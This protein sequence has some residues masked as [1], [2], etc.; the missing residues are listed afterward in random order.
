MSDELVMRYGQKIQATYA[1][2]LAFLKDKLPAVLKAVQEE[3]GG[4]RID[5]SVDSDGVISLALDGH[6]LPLQTLLGQARE[7]MAQFDMPERPA[8]E[9]RNKASLPD[10]ETTLNQDLTDYLRDY[11]LDHRDFST[12]NRIDALFVNLGGR[13]A[14]GEHA[15]F[16]GNHI[17]IVIVFGSGYGSHLVELLDR[18]NIRHMIL[19]DNDPAITRLSL[20]FTDYIAIFNNHL[21]RGTKFTMISSRDPEKL[22]S[23]ITQAI[24]QHWPPFFVHGV[25]L[26]RNLRN[27]EICQQVESGLSERLWLS[28]R[29]WGFFD[30]ELLSVRH[31]IANLANGRHFLQAAK[32]VD[33]KAVAFV[34]A[35]GPSLD[36]LAEQLKKH[37]GK[38]VVVSCGTALS[39]LYRI[40]VVPDFH[41]EMER[42]YTTVETLHHSVPPEFLAQVRV[43]APNVVHPALFDGCKAGLMFLKGGDTASAVFP[44]SCLSIPTFPT[45]SNTA[46]AWLLAH[47]FRTIHLFGVDLGARDPNRHHSKHSI[48]YHRDD[49]PENYAPVIEEAASVSASMPMEAEANF[50][51]KAYTSD[52]LY[53]ARMAIEHDASN[54]NEAKIYNL[55]DGVKIDG[56]EPLKPEDFSLPRGTPAKA[57]VIDDILANFKGVDDFNAADCKA[58]ILKELEALVAEVRM[59]VNLKVS[60]KVTLTEKIAILHRTTGGML[61]K[62]RAAYWALR[63]SLLHQSRRIY[64]YMTFIPDEQQ[65]VAFSEKAFAL[66]GE[67]LDQVLQDVRNIDAK[68]GKVPW[69]RAQYREA[70]LFGKPVEDTKTSATK[71]PAGR[72]AESAVKKPV[73]AGKTGKKAA[74]SSKKSAASKSSAEKKVKA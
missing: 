24:L 53:M 42:P 33:E 54:Y 72:K 18:Y 74:V 28:F 9:V 60:D 63:G 16:G 55:N 59:I 3:A 6:P 17:P 66:I 38:A 44:E 11:Y 1:A 10:T 68:S 34:V 49:L 12:R 61:A 52:I 73:V 65:A 43:V 71:K 21:M 32:G 37:S 4:V 31:S 64:E 56:V 29:G 13:A 47:G 70:E 27:I 23:E 41:I 50:G 30:D 58:A 36:G 69:V 22:I 25:A 15:N 46:V 62:H 20:G 5:A 8:I 57:G 35:N 45:V 48:Y 19:V 67:F 2:N 26:F 51:G 39:A 40:G 14:A 7:C